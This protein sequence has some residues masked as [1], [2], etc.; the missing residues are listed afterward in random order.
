MC[1]HKAQK[2]GKC[3][4]IKSCSYA[5]NNHNILK[6][7]MIRPRNVQSIVVFIPSTLLDIKRC[8]IEQVCNTLSTLQSEKVIFFI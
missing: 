6:I 8:N 2:K 1:Q 5:T 3:S 4:F 7:K